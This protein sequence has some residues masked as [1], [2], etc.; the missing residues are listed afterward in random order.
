MIVWALDLESAE[1]CNLIISGSS[2]PFILENGRKLLIWYW[3]RH[4]DTLHR[5][6]C[7]VQFFLQ[8][9]H[10]R[11]RECAIFEAV[12]QKPAGIVQKRQYGATSMC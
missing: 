8:L 1:T 12:G 5:A 11:R 3:F 7:R 4:G 2:T 6:L 10:N 9:L